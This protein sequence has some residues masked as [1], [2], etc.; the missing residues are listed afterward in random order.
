VLDASV[1]WA[2]RDPDVFKLSEIF[3]SLQGEGPSAGAPAVFVRLA[4]CNLRCSWCDT[5]YTWDFDRYRYDDEVRETSV[6][7]VLE[8]VEASGARRLIVTGGEPLLQSAAIE[9]LLG[10]LP[11]DFTVE[12]ET[13]GT[14]LPSPALLA[15]VDQWNVSAKLAHS[16]E[17]RERRLKPA[18]LATLRD[19]GRAYLKLVVEGEADRDEVQALIDQLEWPRDR[20][21]LMPQA[22]LRDAHERGA[23]PVAKLCG[24]LGVRFSPRLHVLLWGGERGR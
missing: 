6:I 24:E 5:R 22:A 15:R 9:R 18:A 17:S 2:V 13:N 16:G 8:R 20:V 1:R 19:T 11:A 7:E 12:V 23:L 3:T 21:Y 4:L 10:R 14:L